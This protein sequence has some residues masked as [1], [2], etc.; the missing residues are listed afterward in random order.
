[1]PTVQNLIAV[2]NGL[3]PL[4]RLVVAGA[5]AAI[6]VAILAL[7]RTGDGAP[8]ALLYAGLDE[9]AAGAVVSALEAR[10]V[11]YR[12]RSDSIMVNPDE[13]DALRMTLAAEGIPATGGRGYELLDSLTGFGTT[14]QMFDA[15]YWRA[16]EGE[17]ARTIQTLADVRAVRVHLAQGPSDPFRRATEPTASVTLT[18]ASG[19]LGADAARAIRHLVA[20]AVAGMRPEDVQVVDS[21]SGLIGG[22][23]SDA[24]SSTSAAAARADGIRRRVERL[25]AARVGPGNAVVEVSVDLIT[26]HEQVSEH[27]FDPQS[28]VAIS[29]D[30]EERQQQSARQDDNVTVASNLPDGEAGAGGGGSE[31]SSETRERTNFEVSETQ[32]EVL[33]PPGA[34]KRMTIAVL[35]DG[36]MT[37]DASGAMQWAPRSEEEMAALRELVAAAVGLDEGRGDVLTLKSMEFRAATVEGTAPASG[38]LSLFGPID[39]MT[40]IQIAVLALVALALGLFVLRPLLAQARRESLAPPPPP[41]SLTQSER[42]EPFVPESVD[43]EEML[44]ALT[45]GAPAADPADD[46]AARLR[47]LIEERRTES[48][49]ILRGWLEP[50]EEPG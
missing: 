13:R 41:L 3:S 22:P 7:A 48:L 14:S 39:V 5:T 30:I 43:L 34:T 1:M 47:R 11:A 29:T 31:Q 6:F 19:H 42:A 35:V 37:P 8:T 45:Q 21:V 4:R 12:V 24:A 15:A 28:R 20:S 46:P 33:R 10:N 27:I 40:A 44:G 9:R 26:E 18:T 38:L 36:Q 25:L 49:E 17:L 32:R 2:W 23:E 16:K 50:E